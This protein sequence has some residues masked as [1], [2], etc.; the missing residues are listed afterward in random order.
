MKKIIPVLAAA[1]FLFGNVCELP[2]QTSNVISSQDDV[3]TSVY[4]Q[5]LKYDINAALPTAPNDRNLRVK[6]VVSIKNIGNANGSTATF[7]INNKAEILS[8]KVGANT[9]NFRKSE[10]KA[11]N[12]QRITVTLGGIQPNNSTDVTLEYNLPVTENSGLSAISPI[13]TQFLP[14]SAWFPTPNSPFSPRGADFA[15]FSITVSNQNGEVISAGNLSANSASTNLAGQP[16][17]IG[18]SFNKVSAQNVDV[19]I[20]KGSGAAE[21]SRAQELAAVYSEAFNFAAQSLNLKNFTPNAKIVAVRRG[22]GF[23]D[24]GVILVDSAVLRR[25]KIDSQTITALTEAAMKTVFGNFAMVGGNGY[26][27]IREGLARYYSNLF[28]EKK[29]GAEAAENERLRQRTA[30]AAVVKR[31]IPLNQ[32]TPLDDI[33]YVISGSKGAMIWRLVAE[34]IGQNQFNKAVSDLLAQKKS[35]TVNDLRSVL[36]AQNQSVGDIINKSFDEITDTDLMVG[37]PQI[38]NGNNVAALRNLGSFDVSVP[39]MATL[40][41]GQKMTLQVNIPAKSFAE[42]AFQTSAK[43]ARVEIDPQKLF[44]QTDFANDFAPREFTESDLVLEIKRHFDKQDFA[45]A[46]KSAKKALAVY[47][48][49]EDAKVILARALIAQNRLD[50]AEKY[51]RE[52]SESNFSSARSQ[53]WTQFGLGE[54]SEKR[55]RPAEAAKF[56]EN[57]IAIGADYAVSLQS[58]THLRRIR[59]TDVD[60]P[61]KSFF[62]QFDKAVLS[63]RKQNIEDFIVTGELSKFAGGITGSQ[64]EKW[65]TNVLNTN[66]IAPNIFSAE[67]EISVKRL[68][69]EPENVLASVTLARLANGMKILSIESF[70][71][72]TTK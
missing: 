64:P 56:Y 58:K 37:L 38:K 39:V 67:I 32:T 62:A 1:A 43:I 48:F 68:N 71:T 42:A 60:E 53:A 24:S 16:F 46:E 4:W 12:L 65:T 3:R 22:A 72:Q 7:R 18:G 52:L 6:A 54:I 40:E 44:P 69:T 45:A 33:Y 25:P 28:I 14:M 15:P 20:M 9:A 66:Q 47:P 10:E 51:F 8:A 57:A 59:P 63:G 50:E 5:V 21:T 17:F 26:G 36:T 13:E 2:A 30:Y 55:N 49:L 27:S 34:K 19:Y 35:L 23:T 29:F 31:D 70:E 61:V 11:G 41:T